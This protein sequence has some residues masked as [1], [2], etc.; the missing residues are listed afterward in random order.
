MSKI[1]LSCPEN[2]WATL[3]INGEEYYISYTTNAAID[4]LAAAYK[5]YIG[6]G[7]GIFATIIDSEGEGNFYL[8]FDNSC[9]TI[10]SADDD[11]CEHYYFIS[12]KN[13]LFQIYDS[14]KGNEET[15]GH[16]CC[17]EI[18]YTEEI[19]SWLATIGYER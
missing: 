13:L 14:I 8:I 5:N 3:S 4:I 10:C 18:D 11:Y 15:W 2:G 17:D 9:L 16:F 6:K 19:Y 7:R 1:K 12:A